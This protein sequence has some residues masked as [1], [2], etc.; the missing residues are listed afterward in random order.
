L[1]QDD[2]DFWND[3]GLRFDFGFGIDD[4]ARG[5][6]G[7]D[8]FRLGGW[9][10]F[11]LGNGLWGERFGLL[12]DWGRGRFRMGDGFGGG[13]GTAEEVEAAE[14]ADGGG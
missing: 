13:G 8:R 4:E 7:S 2:G 10:S 1:F 14:A 5:L 6:G 12:H 9:G 3:G 11:W